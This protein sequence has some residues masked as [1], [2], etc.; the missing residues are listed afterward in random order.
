[1]DMEVLA[2]PSV[3]LGEEESS[4]LAPSQKEASSDAGVVSLP[5]LLCYYYREPPLSSLPHWRNPEYCV[6]AVAGKE[7]VK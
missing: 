5:F 6:P 1:M 4:G 2:E 3:P 7:Y